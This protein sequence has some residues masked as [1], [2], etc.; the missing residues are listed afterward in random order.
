MAGQLYAKTG[1]AS[2]FKVQAALVFAAAALLISAPALRTAKPM[3][4][5]KP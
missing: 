4:A 5:V 3:A 1:S 2:T